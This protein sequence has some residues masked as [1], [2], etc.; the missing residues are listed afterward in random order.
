[1]HEYVYVR[2]YVCR[3][4]RVF[5]SLSLCVF[6]CTLMCAYVCLSILNKPI[7]INK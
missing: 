6:V 2:V 3:H 7:N 5:V 4:V 1:M